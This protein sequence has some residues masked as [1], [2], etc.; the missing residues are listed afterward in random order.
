MTHI[1]EPRKCIDCG[2]TIEGEHTCIY[3]E[4]SHFDYKNDNFDFSEWEDFMKKEYGNLPERPKRIF[5]PEDEL[6]F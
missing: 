6:P 2:E 1:I 5:G 3:D 4:E